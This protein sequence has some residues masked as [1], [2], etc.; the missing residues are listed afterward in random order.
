MAL[1]RF[2]VSV[3]APTS[4]PVWNFEILFTTILRPSKTFN[5]KPD[6][7]EKIKDARLNSLK[8][9]IPSVFILDKLVKR[10]FEDK[11]KRQIF[12]D[13]KLIFQQERIF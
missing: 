1:E 7:K 5:L 4:K 12:L 11:K 2:F 10:S 3:K 6:K 13:K 8:Q 9:G